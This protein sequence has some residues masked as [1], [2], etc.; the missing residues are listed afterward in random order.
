MDIFNTSPRRKRNHGHRQYTSPILHDVS[1]N[2]SLPFMQ[3]PLGMLHIRSKLFSLPLLKLHA[4][5]NLC[6]V[7]HVTN[8]ISNEYKSTVIVL[9]ITGHR[10]FKPVSIKKYEIDKRSFLKLSFANK[11]LDG[12]NLG[13]ILHH[14]SVKSKI[15]PYSNDKFVPII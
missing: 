7:N 6:L 13:N 8:P 4:L 1:L 11:S 3:K 12:I 10:L 5:Y 15:P 2:S 14:K 9:D